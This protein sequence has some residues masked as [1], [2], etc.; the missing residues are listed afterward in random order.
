MRKKIIAHANDKDDVDC[1]VDVDEDVALFHNTRFQGYAVKVEFD[2]VALA[3]KT[4]FIW[5]ILLPETRA[6]LDLGLFQP[7]R[8]RQVGFTNIEDTGR[9]GL[10]KPMRLW[11]MGFFWFKASIV[12]LLTEG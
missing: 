5:G 3:R 4:L 8:G 7:Y 2:F 6:Y 11:C 9:S 10:K 12:L 1:D